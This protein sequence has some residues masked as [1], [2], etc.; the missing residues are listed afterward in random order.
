MAPKRGEGGELH[1]SLSKDMEA[2]VP[3]GKQKQVCDSGD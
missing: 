3:F 2:T 1:I